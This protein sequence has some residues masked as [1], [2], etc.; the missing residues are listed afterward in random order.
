M[1]QATQLQGI[2]F[3]LDDFPHIGQLSETSW[4]EHGCHDRLIMANLSGFTRQDY[5][6]LIMGSVT[7]AMMAA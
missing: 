4:H 6:G 3:Y 2:V 1:W 5:R 7:S